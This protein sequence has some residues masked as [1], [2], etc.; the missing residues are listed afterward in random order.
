MPTFEFERMPGVEL[1]VTNFAA[2]VQ[3][4]GGPAEPQTVLRLGTPWQI[5]AEWEVIGTACASIHGNWIISGYLESIGEAAEFNLG[6][7]TVTMS[8]C[9]DHEVTLLI[10]GATVTEPGPYKLVTT[11]TAEDE[12][13][14][15]HL[16]AMAGYMEGPILQF[17]QTP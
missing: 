17:F 7:A 8:G 12:A 14:P 5:E 2:K 11:L 4:V 6:E 9:G 3:E 13:S 10:P 1:E 16:H 15:P